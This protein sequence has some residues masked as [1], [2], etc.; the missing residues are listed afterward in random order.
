MQ[1]VDQLVIDENNIAFHPMMG[2]S[3]KLNDIGSEIMMLLKQHKTKE[4]IIEDL[5]EKYDVSEQ[6]LFIDVNDFFSKLRVYGLLS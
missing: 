1:I 4:E 6:E 2:N 3:Y 5:L